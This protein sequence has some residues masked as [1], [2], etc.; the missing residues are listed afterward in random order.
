MSVDEG[1]QSQA[2]LPAETQT[3]EETRGGG[4]VWKN[5]GGREREKKRDVDEQRMMKKLSNV[6]DK[7]F[8]FKS[9]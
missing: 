2:I 8:F 4:I 5:A 1:T 6:L 9:G 7:L 3:R